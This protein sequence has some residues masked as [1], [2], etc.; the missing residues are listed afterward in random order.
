MTYNVW[1]LPKHSFDM[2]QFNS[3]LHYVSDYVGE[4]QDAG[5]VHNLLKYQERICIDAKSTKYKLNQINGGRLK[6]H[7]RIHQADYTIVLTPN[8]TVSAEADIEGTNTCL[9]T[10]KCFSKIIE[11]YLLP[12]LKQHN[13]ASFDIFDI[14]DIF[15]RICIE[16]LGTDMSPKIERLLENQGVET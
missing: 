9:M 8:Y 7:R 16:N 6:Q 2:T 11:E 13:L 4:K 5:L 1:L 10:A 14:F 15:D 12:N 3:T